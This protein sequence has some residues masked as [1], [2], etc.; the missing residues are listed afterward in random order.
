MD[1]N[2][3]V[4]TDMLADLS[5]MQVTGGKRPGCQVPQQQFDLPH[6]ATNKMRRITAA[7]PSPSEKC[8][9]INITR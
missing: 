5:P 3:Q 7:V 4:V 2:V 6:N 8:L 1:L 9:E